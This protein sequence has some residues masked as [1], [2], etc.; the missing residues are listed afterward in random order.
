MGD[1]LCAGKLGTA[2]EDARG[3]PALVSSHVWPF[4]SMGASRHTQSLAVKRARRRHTVE[5]MGFIQFN[6]T[7]PRRNRTL[8]RA[9]EEQDDYRGRLIREIR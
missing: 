1:H 2:I 7:D 3:C 6:P 9:P 8:T 4:L 5:A